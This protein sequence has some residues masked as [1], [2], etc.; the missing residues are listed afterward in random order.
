[1]WATP[2]KQNNQQMYKIIAQQRHHIKKL[3]R[4]L[5]EAQQVLALAA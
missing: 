1:V 3:K 5:I 2:K 4:Q